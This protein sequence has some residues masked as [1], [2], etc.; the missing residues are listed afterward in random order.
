MRERLVA[1]ATVVAKSMRLPSNTDKRKMHC[2]STA[3]LHTRNR[4]WNSP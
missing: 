4:G 1:M 2:G 3:W